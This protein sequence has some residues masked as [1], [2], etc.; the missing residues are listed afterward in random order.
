M[1]GPRLSL[2]DILHGHF[3]EVHALAGLRLLDLAR[4]EASCRTALSTMVH[5][6]SWLHCARNELLPHFEFPVQSSGC[7]RGRKAAVRRIVVALRSEISGSLVQPLRLSSFV[8]ADKLAATVDAAQRRAE[9][10]FAQSGVDTQIAIAAL[11]W[12][13]SGDPLR[14]PLISSG[15]SAAL[16]RS[17]RRETWELRLAWQDQGMLV[18]ARRRG[19][20]VGGGEHVVGRRTALA[21]TCP[22]ARGGAGYGIVGGDTLGG[23]L[24]GLARLRARQ[25]D[26]APPELRVDVHAV[27]DHL[28]MRLLDVRVQAGSSRWG[29]SVGFCTVSPS[30]GDVAKVLID[31]GLL[32]VVCL[33]EQ[34]RE[35]E[36]GSTR[37]PGL[38]A[39][40]MDAPRGTT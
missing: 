6:D 25:R 37:Y 24:G 34:S 33:R 31:E 35:P 18:G 32:V 4:L 21:R 13:F 11:S 20:A 9:R 10:H 12:S 15:V 26:L 36:F 7:S 14:S 17:G 1:G 19:S 2:D 30:H 39:L 38:H 28:S 27:S 5:G 23:Q 8:M 40:S 3:G 29:R 16:L 22:N